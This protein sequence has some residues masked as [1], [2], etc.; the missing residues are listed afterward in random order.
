MK[1]FAKRVS[2]SKQHGLPI[3]ITSLKIP[4]LGNCKCSGN[5]VLFVIVKTS[6]FTYFCNNLLNLKEKQYALSAAVAYRCAM[7]G[8]W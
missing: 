3:K 1:A 4:N 5:A 6:K 2:A 7:N 8:L